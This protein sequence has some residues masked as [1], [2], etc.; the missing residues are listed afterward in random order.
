MNGVDPVAVREKLRRKLRAGQLD[1]RVIDVVWA[2]SLWDQDPRTVTK[3]LTAP[4][5]AATYDQISFMADG[6]TSTP[7]PIVGQQVPVTFSQKPIFVIWT[8]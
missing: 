6:T 7:N 4:F 1:D 2:R 3:T 5:P 8:R